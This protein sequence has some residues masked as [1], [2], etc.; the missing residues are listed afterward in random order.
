MTDY[1]RGAYFASNDAY[2]FLFISS[3]ILA[4]QLME[5]LSVRTSGDVLCNAFVPSLR[6]Y[7][8]LFLIKLDKLEEAEDVIHRVGT[9]TL[10]R[11]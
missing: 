1:V 10:R 2:A 4:A 9:A 8:G 7:R 3:L 11:C 5:Q 6:A